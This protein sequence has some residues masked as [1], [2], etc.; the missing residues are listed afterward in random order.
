M[1][2]CFLASLLLLMLQAVAEQVAKLQAGAAQT[3]QV[4]DAFKEAGLKVGA[5]FVGTAS[6]TWRSCLDKLS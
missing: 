5:A 3:A 1:H 6:L 4:L 2:V